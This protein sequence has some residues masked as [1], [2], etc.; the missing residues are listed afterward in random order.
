MVQTAS[1]NRLDYK[2][3]KRTWDKTIFPLGQKLGLLTGYVLPQA[4]TSKR[5]AAGKVKLQFEWHCLVDQLLQ[6]IKKR[7]K[8]V[9]KDDELV[10]KMMSTLIFNCDEE[11]LNAM[12]K[13]ARLAGSADKKK[14]DNQNASSRQIF[15]ICG[16]Y[17]WP[18]HIV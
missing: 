17:L 14:H 6:K 3:A 10:H 16:K 13:N 15:F 18:D 5:T 2:Q 8:E 9:L 1:G 7:A 4:G 11:S 12:G